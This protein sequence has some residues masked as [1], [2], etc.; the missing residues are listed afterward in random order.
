MEGNI[1]SKQKE[2][3]IKSDSEQF[4]EIHKVKSGNDR[5]LSQMNRSSE[6]KDETRCILEQI[7]GREIDSSVSISLPFYT[8]YGRNIR[9]GRNIFINQNVTFV[10]L[11]GIV[12]NDDVLIGP[13]CR[14]ITVNHLINPKDRRSLTVSPIE[15]KR[16]A[17]IGANVTVLPGVTI[18]ENSIVGA[19]ST[20]TKDVPDNTIVVGSPDKIVKYID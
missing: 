14:L 10:D 9:F 5:L 1:K 3:V 7:T 19:D 13:M 12:I 17:W 18:G 4:K 6:T 11:G 15:V 20:V 2:K 8:D 16:N